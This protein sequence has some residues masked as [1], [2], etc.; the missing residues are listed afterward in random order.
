MLQQAV[1]EIRVNVNGLNGRRRQLFGY[2]INIPSMILE[3]DLP[4][5]LE[6]RSA[7]ADILQQIRS[8]YLLRLHFDVATSSPRLSLSLSSLP[9]FTPNLLMIADKAASTSLFSA[10]HSSRLIGGSPINEPESI[11][12]GQK[13]GWSRQK[14]CEKFGGGARAGGRPARK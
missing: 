4:F 14:S 11:A 5:Q 6:R 2:L 3:L 1:P 13:K 7:A 10:S 9:Y 12:N 8:C